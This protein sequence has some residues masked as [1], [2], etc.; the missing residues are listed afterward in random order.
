MLW[1]LHMPACWHCTAAAQD[2]LSDEAKKSYWSAHI[3]PS[4][5]T[6]AR[7]GGAHFT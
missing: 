1:R 3:D 2:K 7:N 6:G 4:T 5:A